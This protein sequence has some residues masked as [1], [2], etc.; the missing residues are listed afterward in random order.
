MFLEQKYN[1]LLDLI[2]DSTQLGIL[3]VRNKS[4]IFANTPI[5]RLFGPCLE[6]P[7]LY[8]MENIV[9]EDRDRISKMFLEPRVGLQ[10][11]YDITFGLEGAS[12]SRIIV[13]GRIGSFNEADGVSCFLLVNDI[14]G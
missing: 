11:T 5:E 1:F 6:T 3:I 13:K 9:P 10:K 14:S 2:S 4:V 7:L 8:L 12:R